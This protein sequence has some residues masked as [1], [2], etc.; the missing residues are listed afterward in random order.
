MYHYF[1]V[2]DLYLFFFFSSRRRHTRCALVTG[3]QTCALPICRL[4]LSS[5]GKEVLP[6][7]QEVIERVHEMLRQAAQHPQDLTGELHVGASNTIGNYLAGELLGPFI[8]RHPQV[9]LQVSVENT[10]AIT[11]AL[12]ENGRTSGRERGCQSV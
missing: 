7:A 12:L 1:F 6:M 9:S 10:D 3:V 5:R 2:F 11:T 8:A 4:R